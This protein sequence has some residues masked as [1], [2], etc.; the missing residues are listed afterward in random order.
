MCAPVQRSS[1]CL[2]HY[3]SL[4]SL[5]AILLLLSTR[6]IYPLRPRAG[7]LITVIIFNKAYWLGNNLVLS[8]EPLVT[9]EKAGLCRLAWDSISE[10]GSGSR[11]R[12]RP[13]LRCT[14]RNLPAI[15]ND[16]SVYSLT[17]PEHI[18]Q[19]VVTGDSD[20]RWR[21]SGKTQSTGWSETFQW[22]K[23]RSVCRTHWNG[24][25][26][27]TE[28]AISDGSIWNVHSLPK[29]MECQSKGK[30]NGGGGVT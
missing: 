18:T 14:K 22:W 27:R 7:S 9:R 4:P 2:I 20:R 29:L 24:F 30:W 26:G 28:K 10:T 13:L 5:W 6:Q 8:C 16:T 15:R 19:P 12:P 11:R 23:A 25:S 21:R 1:I 17:A 3:S